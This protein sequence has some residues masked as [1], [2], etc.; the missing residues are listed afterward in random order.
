MLLK[1]FEKIIAR[2]VGKF[3]MDSMVAAFPHVLPELSLLA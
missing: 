1:D 2:E 3:N